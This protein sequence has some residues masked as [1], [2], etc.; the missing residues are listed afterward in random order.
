MLQSDHDSLRASRSGLLPVRGI[1][2]HPRSVK[3]VVYKSD[4]YTDNND[5]AISHRPNV[6]HPSQS[7]PNHANQNNTFTPHTDDFLPRQSWEVSQQGFEV[8]PPFFS[9]VAP[10]PLKNIAQS[11]MPCVWSYSIECPSGIAPHYTS[12]FFHGL[13]ERKEL[14]PRRT[15]RKGR[16]RNNGFTSHQ[17]SLKYQS[18]S[19]Q[20]TMNRSNKNNDEVLGRRH[21]LYDQFVLHKD[22][23]L[24][25]LTQTRPIRRAQI[26]QEGIISILHDYTLGI[27]SYMC[28]SSTDNSVSVSRDDHIQSG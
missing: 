4:E 15:S 6:P 10:K 16:I 5:V 18:Q 14:K 19:Q 9:R 26:K 23:R 13:R 25:G 2:E 11:S 8:P 24:Q 1:E 3:N 21:S 22:Q 12:N 20:Q 17:S 7:T 27:V 28:R